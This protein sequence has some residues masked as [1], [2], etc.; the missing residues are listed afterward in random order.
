M[1]RW[2]P[3]ARERLR[4]AGLELFA[5]QGYSA[6]T[7]PEITKRA[8]LTTRTFFRH[9]SDKREVIFGDDEIP[10]IARDALLRAPTGIPP[11]AAIRVG[12]DELASSWFAPKRDHMRFARHVIASDPGLRER[13]LRKRADLLAALQVGFQER[14]ETPLDA[15]VAAAIAIDVLHLA[16]A[17]WLDDGPDHTRE[18]DLQRCLNRVWSSFQRIAEAAGAQHPRGT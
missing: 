4:T 18:D 10:D 1:S 16:L 17:L 9:F 14:G 11:L 15:A 3:D 12:L 7:V 8:G 5:E 2:A 6:T 13:D